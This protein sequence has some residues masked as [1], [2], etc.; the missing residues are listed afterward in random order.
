MTSTITVHGF[1]RQSQHDDEHHYDGQ[2][3]HGHAPL[4]EVTQ[5]HGRITRIR[6]TSSGTDIAACRPHAIHLSNGIVK[7]AL[8]VTWADRM[9]CQIKH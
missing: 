7:V 5:T 3:R 9:P 8:Q 6:D 4:L 2:C 1:Q